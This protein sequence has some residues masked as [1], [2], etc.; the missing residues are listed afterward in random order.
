MQIQSVS[1]LSTQ[2]LLP[3]VSDSARQSSAGVLADSAGL[4]ATIASDQ[5]QA[6]PAT[7][8]EKSTAPTQDDL[9]QALQKI[10]DTLDVFTNKL[11]FSI[12]KDTDIFVVKVVDRETKE[13]IRQ[14]PSEEMLN[15]AKA[16]DKLQGL[17]ISDQA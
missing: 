1:N 14:L 5:Q 6:K 9:D 11:E 15:I 7:T 10:N 16:L 13:V 3:V 4:A 17:L 8:L 12:D 2:A